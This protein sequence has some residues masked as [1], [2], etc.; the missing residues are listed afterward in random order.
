M[1][2]DD[3][4]LK[5]HAR[6][7]HASENSAHS[8]ASMSSHH[9]TPGPLGSGVEVLPT[10]E[11]IVDLCATHQA[12]QTT[13]QSSN[14]ATNQTPACPLLALHDTLTAIQ[15]TFS[16]PF[17]T[18]DPASGEESL[19]ELGMREMSRGFKAML[20]RGVKEVETSGIKGPDALAVIKHAE[21]II[22]G[23]GIGA[24]C[25]RTDMSSE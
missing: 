9:V 14:T 23:R 25:A 20:E 5:W 12:S 1:H 6:R 16:N 10:Y 11:R 2:A 3:G 24:E 13:N 17:H 22:A 21:G 15:T 19:Q 4:K 8:S 18:L 7:R